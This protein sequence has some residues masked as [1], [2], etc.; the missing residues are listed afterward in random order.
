M[1]INEC[2]PKYEP[3]ADLTGHC[4]AQVVGCRFLKIS[5]DK[6]GV[7]YVSDDT[8]GGNIKVAQA[9]AGDKI[10]GVAGYDAA[11]GRKVKV[12]R[13]PGKIVPVDLGADVT[14]GAEV[15]SDA[16]GKAIPLA[17]G[18]AAGYA[19]TGGTNGTRGYIA[20]YR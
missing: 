17:A 19:I 15:Q 18:A 8:S 2:I 5:G 13:G 11:S 6:Q 20:L 1:A 14:A 9:V 10:V 12:V 7:D 3:G 16:N 4:T